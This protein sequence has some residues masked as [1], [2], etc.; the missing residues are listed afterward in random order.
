MSELSE[1]S[2]MSSLKN[3]ENSANNFC[4]PVQICY[5]EEEGKKTIAIAKLF[6]LHENT[7]KEEL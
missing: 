4:Q 3:V 7:I 1:L 5:R 6:A 2:H